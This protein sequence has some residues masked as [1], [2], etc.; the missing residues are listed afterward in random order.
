MAKHLVALAVLLAVLAGG[1]PGVFRAIATA[2][3]FVG[4]G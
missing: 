3:G 1:G 2:W 4:C